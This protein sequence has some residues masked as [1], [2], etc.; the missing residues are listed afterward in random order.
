MIGIWRVFIGIKGLNGRKE[1]RECFIPQYRQPKRRRERRGVL[2]QERVKETFEQMYM[3]H[4]YCR[5]WWRVGLGY[6]EEELNRFLYN[7]FTC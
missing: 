1:L 6:L 5:K 7:L 3:F 2:E 4:F